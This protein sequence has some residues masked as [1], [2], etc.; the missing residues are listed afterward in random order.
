MGLAWTKT[1]ADGSER[2]MASQIIDPVGACVQPADFSPWN[3]EEF[4]SPAAPNSAQA[5]VPVEA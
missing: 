1:A 3:H 4:G 5:D 2:S